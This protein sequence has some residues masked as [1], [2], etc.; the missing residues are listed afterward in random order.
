MKRII[1][2]IALAIASLFSPAS[3][4]EK[5]RAKTD[6]DLD[7]INDR[8]DTVRSELKEKLDK[9]VISK[10]QFGKYMEGLI[11]QWGNWHNWGN[12]NN[13]NNW[14]KWNKWSKWN[15]WTNW[16]KQWGDWNNW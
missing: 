2:T 13:W 9:G 4:K 3:A 12:W 1:L 14:R 11:D 8:I 10:K 5:E 7:R 6:N 16:G 15:D